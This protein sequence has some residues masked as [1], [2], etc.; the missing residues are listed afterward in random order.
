MT[1]EDVKKL[2]ELAQAATPGPWE[3][4][5]TISVMGDVK[6]ETWETVCL[7]GDFMGSDEGEKKAQNEANARY[8][9][10]ANPAAVL[11]LI[12]RVRQ[13]EAKAAQNGR[14]ADAA[15][16]DVDALIRRVEVAEEKEHAAEEQARKAGERTRET[17]VYLLV[18]LSTHLRA[19]EE[20]CAV[21]GDKAGAMT[22]AAKYE[23]VDDAIERMKRLPLPHEAR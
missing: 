10:A 19:C 17:D 9:A 4:D 8:I 2:G 12:E 21:M 7:T 23:V 11:A 1:D 5:G 22:Y 18:Q 6:P 3:V 16:D 15:S 14:L 20:S 13:A